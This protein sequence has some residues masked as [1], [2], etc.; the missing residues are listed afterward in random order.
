MFP[1]LKN[2]ARDQAGFVLPVALFLLIA[3]AAL[4]LGLSRSSATVPLIAMQ[5]LYSQRAYYAADSGA[6]YALSYLLLRAEPNR[7]DSDGYCTELNTAQISYSTAGLEGCSA[8]LSCQQRAGSPNNASYYIITSK[9]MCGQAPYD[10]S[11]T[12]AVSAY[13]PGEP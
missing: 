9:G 11:R 12:I 7:S 13:L 5:E 4:A 6:N 1:K 10:A 3:A 2:P 8:S